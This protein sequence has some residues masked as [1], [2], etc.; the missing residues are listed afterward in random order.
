MRVEETADEERRGYVCKNNASYAK[1]IMFLSNFLCSEYFWLERHQALGL[2][3]FLWFI[4]SAFFKKRT[5]NDRETRKHT[6]AICF[7]SVV[8]DNDMLKIN[9][10]LIIIANLP[11]QSFSWKTLIKFESSGIFYF[12][13]LRIAKWVSTLKPA[14]SCTY[15][16]T[17]AANC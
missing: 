2:L 15:Y 11:S 14:L 12:Q 6:L 13:C 16:N 3:D 5:I 1:Y 9:E 17:M 8:K 4:S 10:P 7:V